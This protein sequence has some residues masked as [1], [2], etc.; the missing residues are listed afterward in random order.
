MP[1]NNVRSTN[2]QV[3]AE[4]DMSM[5][6]N[7]CV[8]PLSLVEY[9]QIPSGKR[10]FKEVESQ[11]EQEQQQQQQQLLLVR[12]IHGKPI[13]YASGASGSSDPRLESDQHLVFDNSFI[14]SRTPVSSQSL[15]ADQETRRSRSGERDTLGQYQQQSQQQLLNHNQLN[16]HAQLEGQQSELHNLYNPSSYLQHHVRQVESRSEDQISISNC[17]EPHQS[18]LNHQLGQH[19]E[20]REASTCYVTS[21]QLAE[22]QQPQF[23]PDHSS[24]YQAQTAYLH[25]EPQTNWQ[26]H[27]QLHLPPPLPIPPPH[28][29]H[30]HH[31]HHGQQAQQQQQTLEDMSQEHMIE[32]HQQQATDG[33]LSDNYSVRRH[34]FVSQNSPYHLAEPTYSLVY[35]PDCNTA[36]LNVNLTT[37][38]QGQQL[39]LIDETSQHLNHSVGQIP[40]LLN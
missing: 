16:N 25:V 33:L 11:R 7:G 35:Q 1:I 20:Q 17:F 14:V 39:L 10:A 29:Q 2:G 8:L 30:Q 24:Y 6:S 15:H 26:C 21:P 32:Q 19:F 31:H 3:K 40:Q 13:K 34:N 36:Q 5:N 22:Q 9:Q 27:S 18:N 4:R 12:Q 28:H 23:P 37:N 38:N